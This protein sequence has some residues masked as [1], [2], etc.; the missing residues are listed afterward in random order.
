MFTQLWQ[1]R[2]W[3]AATCRVT[4][5]MKARPRWA[6]NG[7]MSGSLRWKVFSTYWPA[8]IPDHR[9]ERQDQVGQRAVGL[10]GQLG[11]AGPRDRAAVRVDRQH[12]ADRDVAGRRYRAEA[13]ARRGQRAGQAS[14]VAPAPHGDR[15]RRAAR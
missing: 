4:E 5:V 1:R 7:R 15:G 11:L 8:G 13:V 10:P 9:G 6:R 14:I 2:F 12:A 3:F